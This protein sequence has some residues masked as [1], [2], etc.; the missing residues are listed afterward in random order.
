MYERLAHVYDQL[1]KDINYIKWANYIERLFKVHKASPETIVD[2][3]CG[4]GSLCLELAAR[5]YSSIGIDISPDMLACADAKLQRAKAKAGVS[6]CDLPVENS[7]N[8]HND[9]EHEYDYI[10]GNDLY[11]G[12]DT[13]PEVQFACSDISS[14]KLK[15][16]ADVFLCMLDSLNYLTK[17]SG[18]GALFNRVSKYL[19]KDGIFIFDVHSKYKFIEIL[20]GNQSHSIDDDLCY[21]CQS[22][23]N[24]KTGICTHE[25]TVFERLGENPVYSRFDETHRERYYGEEDLVPLLEKNGLVLAARYGSFTLKSPEDISERIFYVCRKKGLIHDHSS[26][27]CK[28]F[29]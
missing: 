28:P 17:I 16:T 12:H 14:F 27:M 9:Y 8:R 3:G 10:S 4:T 5:G 24:N 7:Q 11:S 6:Y 2:L 20:D 26:N 22:M 25:M 1:T 19:S 29:L 21:F 23:Y 18:V 13:C 15:G